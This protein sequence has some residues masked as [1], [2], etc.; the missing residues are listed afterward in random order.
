MKILIFITALILGSLVHAKESNFT[1]AFEQFILNNDVIALQTKPTLKQGVTIV[2][3]GVDNTCDYQNEPIQDA[4]D[5]GFVHIRVVGGTYTENLNIDDTNMIIEGGYEDCVKA[6]DDDLSGGSATIINGSA[7]DTV[8]TITIGGNDLAYDITL[9]RLTVRNGGDTSNLLWGGG[10]SVLVSQANLFLDNLVITNNQANFGGGLA[11]FAGSPTI[12]IFDTNFT[13]NNAQSGG[14]ISCNSNDAQI[15]FYDSGNAARG[16]ILLNTAT[17]RSGGGVEL[18]AGCTFTLYSGQD[19][20]NIIDLRG[21][22]SNTAALDG[23]GVFV[24][25]S[26]T[27]TA[28]GFQF[29]AGNNDGPATIRGNTADVDDNN[30]GE[31]GG[32]YATGTDTTVSLF[33]ANVQSNSA[34]NGGGVAIRDG[35]VLNTQSV[36]FFVPCWNP[37]KCNTFS[38]NTANAW[39][40]AFYADQEDDTLGTEMKIFSSHIY[41]NSNDGG[42]GAAAYADGANTNILIEGSVIY[43]NTGFSILYTFTDAQSTYQFNTIADNDSGGGVSGTIVRNFGGT[44]NL[45]NSIV[46]NTTLDDSV[47]SGNGSSTQ[48]FD[49]VITHEDSSFSGVFISVADPQFID[50]AGYDYH[51]DAFLSPAVDYCDD[52]NPPEITTDI[53]GEQRGWDDYVTNDNFAGSFWDIGADETYQNDVIFEDGLE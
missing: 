7:D 50:R 11:V 1:D 38:E 5:D 41:E 45:T 15:N 19:P 25:S 44:I 4:I 49:C 53:D 33:N 47:Y 17:P 18:L 52:A 26:S 13:V 40:G 36:N 39:G 10:I 14:A 12:N 35:A 31:G 46:H 3:V 51:I 2:T 20:D 27:F 30:T 24:D 37:G 34:V 21:I 22:L 6:V 48:T 28:A 16:S 9:S 42:Q 32:I 23:G 8:S 43:E 29:L